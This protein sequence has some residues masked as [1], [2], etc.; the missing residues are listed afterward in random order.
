MRIAQGEMQEKM[1][2]NQVGVDANMKT[3]MQE[4]IAKIDANQEK[5]EAAVHSIRSELDGKIQ[6]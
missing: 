6:R 3:H 4:I 5:M 2:A 1:D